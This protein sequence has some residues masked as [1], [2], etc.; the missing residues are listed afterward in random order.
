MSRGSL[1]RGF[2]VGWSLSRG[3]LGVFG[4]GGLCVEGSLSEGVSVQ[5][6]FGEVVSLWRGL[7]LRGVSV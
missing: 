1:F 6:V 5:G 4:G 2:S 3:S 7:C